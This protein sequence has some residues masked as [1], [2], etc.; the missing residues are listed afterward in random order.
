M[1]LYSMKDLWEH[2]AFKA[3]LNH[4][5]DYCE[6]LYEDA[7]QEKIEGVCCA[8]HCV[9]MCPRGWAEVVG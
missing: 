9:L 7:A 2:K 8:E 3:D 1:G 5:E 6:K 4:I